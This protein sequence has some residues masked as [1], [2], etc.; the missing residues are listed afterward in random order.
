M[1]T[2]IKIFNTL[3]ALAALCIAW[4]IFLP[5]TAGWMSVDQLAFAFVFCIACGGASI[6]AFIYKEAYQE[7]KPKQPCRK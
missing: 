4:H 7:Y 6:S 2:L 1:D 5:T 3:G